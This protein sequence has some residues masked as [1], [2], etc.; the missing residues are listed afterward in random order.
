MRVHVT[1]A[2]GFVGQH[3]L[4]QL[5]ASGHE[6]VA[7]GDELDLVIHAGA[8]V[9]RERCARD[10]NYA[11][12]SNVAS[13]LEYAEAC[14]ENDTSMVYVSSVEA[15]RGGNLYALTKHWAEDA[16]R[17]ALPSE[18]LSIARLGAQY[19]PGARLGADTLSNFLQAAMR[20]ED[21]RVYRD[22]SRTWTYVEDSARALVIIAE[23]ALRWREHGR[24]TAE[25]AIFDVDSGEQYALV[26]VAEMVVR[27]VGSGRAVEVT[28]PPGYSTLP[29]ADTKRLRALDW[30]PQITFDVG[31]ARTYSW[32]RESILA[33][34]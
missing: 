31:L 24:H 5:A 4:G 27:A 34:A 11:L 25:P 22:T 13:T 18:H 23:A 8:C 30:E 28:A 6:V 14:A 29:P 32:L 26:E 7:W 21:L 16:C 9:G 19:G 12:S 17:L 1:G 20:G 33:A 10:K 2:K 3:L 15:T